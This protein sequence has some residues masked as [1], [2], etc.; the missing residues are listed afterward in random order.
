MAGSKQESKANMPTMDQD[1][2]QEDQIEDLIAKMSRKKRPQELPNSEKS[3]KVA[4]IPRP[5]IALN[6]E[7][8]ARK[9]KSKRGFQPKPRD[10]TVVKNQVSKTV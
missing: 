5:D 7:T 2:D 4:N 1:Q 6:C 3:P 8:S 10:K 9:R